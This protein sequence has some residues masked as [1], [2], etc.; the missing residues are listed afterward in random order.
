MAIAATK[1]P[2]ARALPGTVQL[3]SA[4]ATLCPALRSVWK[5]AAS[6]STHGKRTNA[7]ARCRKASATNQAS[8]KLVAL[9]AG[10]AAA[11]RRLRRLRRRP[12]RRRQ[13]EQEFDAGKQP[14]KKR[15]LGA[16]CPSGAVNG[17]P[18]DTYVKGREVG[19][20]AVRTPPLTCGS[21]R[22]GSWVLWGRRCEGEQGPGSS[23]LSFTND[24]SYRGVNV[25]S[26]SVRC[27]SVLW[28]VN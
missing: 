22:D 9:R 21:G 16:P 2:I 3:L 24:E 12:R 15:L 20:S 18:P 10:F 8:R 17:A 1:C 26:R 25:I 19:E 5:A 11:R 27:G 4:T 7:R 23:R 13:A 28:R 6:A 14:G